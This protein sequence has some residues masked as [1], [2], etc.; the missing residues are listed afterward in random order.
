MTLTFACF[1][2][3][4]VIYPN[5]SELKV[6]RREFFFFGGGGRERERETRRNQKEKKVV[7]DK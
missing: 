1:L 2:R 3:I 7:E 5:K 6:T 4:R